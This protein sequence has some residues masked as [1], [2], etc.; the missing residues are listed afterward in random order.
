MERVIG[1]EPEHE[2]ILDRLTLGGVSVKKKLKEAMGCKTDRD[3][4]F[5]LLDL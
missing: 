1:H 4:V 3:L 2:S 5:L